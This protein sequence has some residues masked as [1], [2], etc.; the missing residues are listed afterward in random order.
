MFIKSGKYGYINERGKRVVKPRFAACWRFSEGLA[1]VRETPEGKSGYINKQG[2]YAIPPR[3][4]AASP[5]QDGLAFVKERDVIGFINPQGEW[6]I[7]KEEKDAWFDS[8][9]FNEGLAG[10]GRGM[11][12]FIDKSGKW[13]IFQEYAQVSAFSEGRAAVQTKEGFWCYID[14]A[15]N[16][17]I[18]PQYWEA[19]SFHCGIAYAIDSE[20]LKMYI[21]ETGAPVF[22]DKKDEYAWLDE[23]SE[24]LGRVVKRGGMRGFKYSMGFMDKTGGEAIK[25]EFFN[26]GDFQEGLAPACFKPNSRWGYID[27]KGKIVIG[28]AYHMAMPFSGGLAAV[29][30]KGRGMGYINK[31]GN[32][33]I[34]F[35]LSF[36]GKFSNGMAIYSD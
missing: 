10:A 4:D 13:V 29:G 24:G 26:C 34:G 18:S 35:D 28:M 7:K 1:E 33:A 23:F 2:E 21:N 36:A 16:K 25:P 17:V 5:F 22:R 15:G 11:K 27:D 31:E 9:G 20:G 6:V 12:G 19:Y 14:K 3:F 8:Q 30:I 32:T